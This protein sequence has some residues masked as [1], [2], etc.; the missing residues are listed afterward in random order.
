M[1]ARSPIDQ[2]IFMADTDVIDRDTGVLVEKPGRGCPHG[3]KNKPKESA[4]AGSSSSAS[5]KWHTGRPLGS[6]NKPKLSTSFATKPLD[7][8]TVRNNTPPPSSGNIFSFFR[9]RWCSM[10]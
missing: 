10:P 2:E 8:A 4:M 1:H 9:F 6:K 3:S 7:A 5:V